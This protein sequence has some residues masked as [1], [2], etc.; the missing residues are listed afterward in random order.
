MAAFHSEQ[1]HTKPKASEG[2]HLLASPTLIVGH[3]CLLLDPQRPIS[4]PLQCLLTVLF[5][6][7]GSFT[8]NSS[9]HSFLNLWLPP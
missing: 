7:L 2:L 8:P 9:T 6:V 5:S 4:S 1:G 3:I